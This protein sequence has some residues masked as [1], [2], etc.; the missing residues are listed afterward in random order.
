M[1]GTGTKLV[2]ISLVFIWDLVDPVW[3]RSAIPNGSTY[4]GD[5]IRYCAIPVSNQCL[6]SNGPEHM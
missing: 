6:I 1:D 5:F 4:E 2:R 3:I